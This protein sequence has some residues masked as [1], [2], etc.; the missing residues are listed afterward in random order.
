MLLRHR[1][2]HSH[3]KKAHKNPHCPPFSLAGIILIFVKPIKILI[4]FQSILIS[5]IIND[6]TI[7]MVLPRII[8][9][10]INLMCHGNN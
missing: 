9:I 5:V 4:I 1:W 10:F 8:T 3:Y 2:Y 7:I 6:A